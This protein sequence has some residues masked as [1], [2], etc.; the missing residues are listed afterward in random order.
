MGAYAYRREF[1]LAYA[2]L[3]ASSLQARESL[4]QLRALEAGERIRVGVVSPPRGRPVD[5]PEDYR[6]FVERYRASSA[7]RR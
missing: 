6:A 1:L 3:P 4:E 7:A 2:S 5:T